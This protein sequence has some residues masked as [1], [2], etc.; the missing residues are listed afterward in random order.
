MDLDLKFPEVADMRRASRRRL[1]RFAYDYLDSGTGRELGVARNRAAL[2]AINFMPAI[3]A[4]ET[5][6]DLQTEFMGQTYGLPVGVAPVGM[7][8]M[9]WPGAEA[10]LARM[11]QTR[12]VPYCLSTVATR[13]PEEIGPI[14]GDMGWFQLYAPRKAEI[15]RD[16]LRRV[17]E[18]GFTKLILTVDVPGDS[19][20]ERQRRAHV[21]MPP[22]ITPLVA[23]EIATHPE[24][25][26]RTAL[27]GSPDVVLPASYLTP[28][29]KS[30]DS[31]MHAG[32]VI[33]G[34]PDWEYFAALREDW[35]GDLLV[36]GV[37]DP[38]D[39]VRLV[40]EGAD[41]I[42]VS[43]HSARQL[44]A[45][46]ATI[47]QLPKI[48]AALG[49]DVPVIFDSGVMGGLDIMRALALGADFLMMGRAWH[50]ALGALRAKGPDWLATVIEND[51]RT[52]MAQLGV[53]RFDQLASRL[54]DPV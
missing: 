46:P 4:G 12:R 1:P 33:R 50:Y 8:G 5:T 34:F 39:A 15:R 43:N 23:W 7:S 42:W 53:E 35:K 18:A 36:K 45:A 40:K 11:A 24:W 44:D 52:N 31:F 32:R 2:D 30:A 28:E 25:A 21:A 29:Q 41:A 54:I 9:I 3:L 27:A 51:L 17:R 6:A 49:P 14:A 47:T 13:L 16:I 26:I 37:M 48:R 38:D 22:R 10:A 19:R 20:R